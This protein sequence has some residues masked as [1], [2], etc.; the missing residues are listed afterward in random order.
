[1]TGLLSRL[2]LRITGWGW[3]RRLFTHRFGR[4]VAMRFVAGETLEGPVLLVCHHHAASYGAQ[5]A[6][7][8]RLPPDWSQLGWAGQTGRVITNGPL[9]AVTQVL[10]DWTVLRFSDVAD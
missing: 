8:L 6:N 2:I 3:V 10:P 4:R 1:M 9:P 5:P 7:P